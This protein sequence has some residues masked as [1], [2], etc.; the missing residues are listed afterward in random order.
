MFNFIVSIQLVALLFDVI[1]S[2]PSIKKLSKSIL[3]MLRLQIRKIKR[4]KSNGALDTSV[5]IANDTGS[6]GETEFDRLRLGDVRCLYGIEPVSVL[7]R[8]RSAA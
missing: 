1:K 7:D 4:V 8:I 6:N 3:T 5:E 2:L